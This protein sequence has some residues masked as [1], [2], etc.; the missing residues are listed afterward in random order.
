MPSAVGAALGAKWTSPGSSSDLA[1]GRS[2]QRRQRAPRPRTRAADGTDR[3]PP[4]AR[5][6]ARSWSFTSGL[7]RG[8]ALRARARSR[9]LS[10][11]ATHLPFGYPVCRVSKA[12]PAWRGEGRLSECLVELGCRE[13]ALLFG[14]WAIGCTVRKCALAYSGALAGDEHVGAGSSAPRSACLPL[15][16]THTS[17][18]GPERHTA[19]GTH[20][21]A[22]LFANPICPQN[23]PFS[24][25]SPSVRIVRHSTLRGTSRRRLARCGSLAPGPGAILS[26]PSANA[27]AAASSARGDTQLT[28]PQPAARAQ[29]RARARRGAHGAGA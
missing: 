10:S 5:A 6:L 28:A 26:G 14:L 29:R 16:H 12:S 17:L 2:R 27:G 19:H 20:S 13:S 11:G 23:A 18:W 25:Q 3:Q 9:Q 8:E 22:A 4:I 1:L 7:D 24:H 21:A 15:W